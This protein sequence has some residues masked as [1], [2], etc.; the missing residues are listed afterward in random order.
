[1]L[2]HRELNFIPNF[3]AIARPLPNHIKTGSSKS[4]LLT[5]AFGLPCLCTSPNAVE[6]PGH[7]FCSSFPIL[8]FVGHCDFSL[9][10]RHSFKASSQSL[11]SSPHLSITNPQLLARII[12]ST[13]LSWRIMVANRSVL[14][15]LWKNLAE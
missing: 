1:M 12:F 10:F 15:S 11:Q 13:P 14:A 3:T 4:P 5:P 9:P 6:R 7:A 2:H 8:F